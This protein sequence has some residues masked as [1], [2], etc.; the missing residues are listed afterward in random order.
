MLLL[1]TCLCYA[2]SCGVSKDDKMFDLMPTFTQDKLLWLLQGEFEGTTLRGI[3]YEDVSKV[4]Q[5]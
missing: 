3:A 4:H 1:L 5:L 2:L